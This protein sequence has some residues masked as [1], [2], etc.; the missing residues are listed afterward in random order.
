MQKRAREPEMPGSRRYPL[1]EPAPGSRFAKFLEAVGF[2]L[3][4]D[5]QTARETILDGWAQGRTAEIHDLLSER[6]LDCDDTAVA[7]VINAAVEHDRA[8][9][10]LCLDYLSGSPSKRRG[11]G[12]PG[13]NRSYLM[14]VYYACEAERR[15]QSVPEDVSTRG[16]VAGVLGLVPDTV[17]KARKAGQRWVYRALRSAVDDPNGWGGAAGAACTLIRDRVNEIWP[18][19]RA[20]HKGAH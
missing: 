17:G 13:N 19:F 7:R 2:A 8:V 9:N 20:S 16:D 4:D 15:L 12:A 1:R 18:E 3:E 11:R 6:G 14:A 5:E 10:S